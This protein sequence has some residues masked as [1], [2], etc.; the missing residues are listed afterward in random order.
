MRERHS[1]D[2]YW[3]AQGERHRHRLPR[4]RVRRPIV[5][6]QALSRSAP[7]LSRWH[8]KRDPER[9]TSVSANASSNLR[10]ERRQTNTER[11]EELHA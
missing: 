2:R 3:S 4:P 1:A 8:R 6:W 11:P 7:T 10:A 9:G 5:F